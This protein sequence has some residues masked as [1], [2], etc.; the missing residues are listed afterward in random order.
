MGNQLVK[1]LSIVAGEQEGQCLSTSWFLGSLV[2]NRTNPVSDRQPYNITLWGL[3]Q[4]L[5]SKILFCYSINYSHTATHITLHSFFG[6]GMIYLVNIKMSFEF[7][8]PG[9]P[10]RSQNLK[11]NTS[12]GPCLERAASL[13]EETRKKGWWDRTLGHSARE[14][15][16]N[17]RSELKG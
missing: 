4:S 1:S 7:S 9:S 12:Y 14:M 11:S 13:M 5:D 10:E 17:H 2:L 3:F 6:Y 8:F 15:R 16:R